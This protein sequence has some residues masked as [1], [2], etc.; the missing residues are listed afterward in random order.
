MKPPLS[1]PMQKKKVV[2][3]LFAW[4]R[5]IKKNLATVETMPLRSRLSPT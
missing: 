5:K 1:T 4:E 3:M 2:E